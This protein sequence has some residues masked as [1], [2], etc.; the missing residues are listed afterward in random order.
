MPTYDYRCP[1][2]HVHEHR[3]LMSEQP[4]ET[5]CP[6][7]DAPSTV[8]ILTVPHV[9]GISQ[10]H[11]PVDPPRGDGST[12]IRFEPVECLECNH[13]DTHFY[14]EDG[15]LETEPCAKCGS[16]KMRVY[17]ADLVNSEIRF[18]YYDEFLGVE[19]TSYDHRRRIKRER[20]LEEMSDHDAKDL[21]DLRRP[22]HEWQDAAAANREADERHVDTD[23]AFAKFRR[24]RD[25]GGL[26]RYISNALAN[27]DTTFRVHARPASVP[28]R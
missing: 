14:A 27:E 2:G 3:F 1:N 22:L 5:P 20:G 10:T 8:A 15:S 26:D 6:T 23:P 4:D 11:A 25:G 17:K 19:I 24:W 16:W 28:Q 21:E 9:N 13:R 12:V 18:P 7:C